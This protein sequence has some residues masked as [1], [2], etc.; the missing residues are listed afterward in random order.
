MGRFTGCTLGEA[1][2][3]GATVRVTA[4]VSIYGHKGQVKQLFLSRL[5]K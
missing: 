2:P 4:A 5:S 1:I 3:T